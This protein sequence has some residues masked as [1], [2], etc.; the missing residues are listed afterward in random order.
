MTTPL[1]VQE[2]VN[3]FAKASEALDHMKPHLYSFSGMTLDIRQIRCHLQ[4]FAERMLTRD[5]SE[6]LSAAYSEFDTHPE[7]QVLNDTIAT[8]LSKQQG[9]LQ[10]IQTKIDDI[11]TQLKIRIPM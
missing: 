4:M 9:V 10:P 2:I 5:L 7:Y 3:A 6:E 11:K 8:L 1:T